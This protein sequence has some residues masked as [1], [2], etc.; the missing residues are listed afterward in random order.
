MNI[1]GKNSYLHGLTGGCLL[2]WLWVLGPAPGRGIW[3]WRF[4][5][6]VGGGSRGIWGWL[7][8]SC[9]VAHGGK[10]FI[11]IFRE[12]SSSVGGAFI[13][14]GAWELGY[15]SMQFRQFLDIS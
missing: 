4:V 1:L 10:G 12:F 8:F 14:A 5:F 11:C 3:M 6:L 7:W 2:T 13:L 15:Y 9:G